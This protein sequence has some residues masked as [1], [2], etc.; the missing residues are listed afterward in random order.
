MGFNS[1]IKGDFMSLHSCSGVSSHAHS[2][3]GHD[4][5][6]HSCEHSDSDLHALLHHPISSSSS[7][8]DHQFSLDHSEGHCSTQLHSLLHP[9]HQELSHHSASGS[10]KTISTSVSTFKI[11]AAHFAPFESPA[12]KTAGSIFKDAK[13]LYK[14]AEE[15]KDLGHEI[16]HRE[17]EGQTFV[18]SHVC[19]VLESSVNFGATESLSA[20]AK[21]AGGIVTAVGFASADPAVVAVGVALTTEGQEA[22]KEFGK[23]LR[24]L[25]DRYCAE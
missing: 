4:Y 18:Q 17:S 5:H 12:L 10:D 9:E 21:V 13:M 6:P 24:S 8:A 16:H 11:A 3:V 19:P 15:I 20:A 22:A 2:H 14:V 25:I 7:L 1:V 23:D